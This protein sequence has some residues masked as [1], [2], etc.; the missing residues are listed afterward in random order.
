MP[1]SYGE[2][3]MYASSIAVATFWTYK[4]Y[5]LWPSPSASHSPCYLPQCLFLA[6][7][8]L[9]LAAMVALRCI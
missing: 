9:R 5:G 7:V 1:A 8:P 4:H 3:M 2:E 6:M